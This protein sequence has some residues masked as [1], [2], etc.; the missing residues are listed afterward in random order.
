VR[1]NPNANLHFC[2]TLVLFS[3]SSK[4]TVALVG[5]GVSPTLTV[6][7]AEGC[8]DLGHSLAGEKATREF[9]LTNSS[10]FPLDY[11]IKPKTRSQV[12]R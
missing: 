2:E 4:A 8:L 6:E 11:H 1:F 9:Y 3:T 12:G 7:P 10:V 5:Q